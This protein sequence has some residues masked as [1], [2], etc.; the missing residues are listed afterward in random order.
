MATS[1]RAFLRKASQLGFSKS[2]D[3][4]AADAAAAAATTADGWSIKAGSV[5]TDAPHAPQ[6][7]DIQVYP[8]VGTFYLPSATANLDPTTAFADCVAA[9]ALSLSL[10]LDL[11]LSPDEAVWLVQAPAL[12]A[13]PAHLAAAVNAAPEPA[14]PELPQQT[15]TTTTAT[16]RRPARQLL[17]ALRRC[18]GALARGC[19]AVRSKLAGASACFATSRTAEP[20]CTGCP[21]RRIVNAA[22][23]DG[24]EWTVTHVNWS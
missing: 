20:A 15:A 17:C 16:S 21:G 23:V 24:A 7:M 4:D 3:R 11:E 8:P 9:A 13:E 14:T 5:C 22:A 6:C 10:S 2:A 19:A 1:P 18:G 12:P